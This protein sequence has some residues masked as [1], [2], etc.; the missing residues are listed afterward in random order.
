MTY[1]PKVTVLRWM[2]LTM[3]IGNFKRNQGFTLI[4]LMIVIS[5]IAILMTMAMP[6]Y[7]VY[8]LRGKEAVLKENLATIREV[9]DQFKAD[10][11]SYPETLQDLVEK[12]YIKSVPQDPMTH[13]NET[14]ILMPSINDDETGIY[15]I[16]SGSD[17]ISLN[18][19]PYNEW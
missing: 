11:G 12:E 2:V 13:S 19:T 18:G 14:W 10:T 9:L 8:T 3:V 15:D 6:N 5:I 1:I 7:A 17:L 16:H 4:E